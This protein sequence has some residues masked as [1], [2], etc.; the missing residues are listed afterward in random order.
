[1]TRSANIL[2][3]LHQSAHRVPDRAAL[4]MQRDGRETRCSFRRLWEMTDRFSTALK[5]M[6][7]RPDQRLIIMI[8]MS[9]EL[10]VV[11]LG[12]IKIG[13][14]AVF[15]DPWVGIGRINTFASFAEPVG[16]VG[17]AAAHILRMF[18]PRLR[19][20]PLSISTG[21]GCSGF[22]ARNSLRRMLRSD[23]DGEIVDSEP[24]AT[25]LI[26]FTGGSG[27]I[28]KGADRSHRF[29]ESQYTALDR[30][31]PLKD[32]DIDMPMF[33]VFALAN[34]ARGITSVI[35]EMD[36]R[37]VSRMDPA[38]I[39][40]QQHRHEVTTCTASP[41][42]FDRIATHLMEGKADAPRLRRILTGGGPVTTEQLRKWTSVFRHTRIEIVYGS[43]EAEPVAHITASE[44]MSTDTGGVSRGYCVGKPV[45][46]AR[47]IAIRPG[48]I[49]SPPDWEALAVGPDG[50]GELL[51]SG[52]QVC[53]R[54]FRNPDATAENKLVDEDGRV[55]HRMGDTG[56]FDDRGRFR[57][58][59]RVHSTI[60]RAGTYYHAQLIEQ[61]AQRLFPGTIQAA[62]LGLPDGILGQ[63]IVLIIRTK[64]RS[65][66]PEE[67]RE[68]L[69]SEGIPVDQII[70]SRSELPVDPRHNT[71]I[72]TERLRRMVLRGKLRP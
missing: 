28:P 18:S 59:G 20:L 51:V 57:L 61:L 2:H 13:A 30:E 45:L 27:G 55:W 70:F 5:S 15:V 11:M 67:L 12:V 62:A 24:D 22:F 34:L 3:H 25:A 23:G 43:T 47:L 8:P 19:R 6:G 41:P 42:F 65:P 29:L 16:L 40:R 26:T 63:R 44:R 9:V 68:G 53:R 14:V 39:I 66:D 4:I 1:M 60:I 21:S 38:T 31:F 17:P 54:Y 33:P 52:D 10:Y 71:K 48:T 37:R 35:P 49:P 72:D 64:E 56:Y 36:F 46:A 7:C 69:L 32:G 58:V 50:I